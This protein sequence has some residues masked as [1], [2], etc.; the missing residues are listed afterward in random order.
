MKKIYIDEIMKKGKVETEPGPDRYNLESSFGP[1]VGERC[2]MRPKN[3][4]FVLHL[5]KQKKLP[6]PGT[7]I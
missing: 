6:G 2:S 5:E 7:Y 3:D 4:P 1:K